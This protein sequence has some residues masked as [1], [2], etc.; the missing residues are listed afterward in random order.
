MRDFGT[1]PLHHDRLIM[2]KIRK[3]GE[4]REGEL[5]CLLRERQK[6]QGERESCDC[7]RRETQSC[8]ETEM[9]THTLTHSWGERKQLKQW[10]SFD[11]GEGDGVAACQHAYEKERE[12]ICES[13]VLCSF[14]SILWGELYIGENILLLCCIINLCLLK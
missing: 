2:R 4:I 3:K 14:F 10:H 5:Y 7:D 13:S 6:L 12:R 9:V 11:V 8:E 1:A